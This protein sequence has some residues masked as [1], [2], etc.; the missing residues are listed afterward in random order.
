MLLPPSDL[1]QSLTG[2]LHIVYHLLPLQ[3]LL[4][5]LQHLASQQQASRLPNLTAPD[6]MQA[7][8]MLA[9][10]AQ[11][12]EQL[13]RLQQQQVP[14]KRQQELKQHP[15]VQFLCQWLTRVLPQME[16]AQQLQLL[17]RLAAVAQAGLG[18]RQRQHY[19]LFRDV[20]LG[21]AP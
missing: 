3:N 17:D 19:C 5:L 11:Q 8:E 1:A 15:G 20:N 2:S 16:A 9:A 10:A 21:Q 4:S 6:A 18:E 12:T 14:S 7:A 13:Q